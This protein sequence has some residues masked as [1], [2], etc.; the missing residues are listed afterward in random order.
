MTVHLVQEQERLRHS[1][2]DSAHLATA[3]SSGFKK[4]KGKQTA[5]PDFQKKHK[6]SNTEHKGSNTEH[7]EIK[8]FF[9]NKA[10]HLKK[11]CAKYKAWRVK[12][13]TSLSLVNTESLLVSVAK[14]TWWLDTGTTK[15]I[16][17]SL[18]GCRANRKPMESERFLYMGAGDPVQVEGIATFG[19]ILC[20]GYILELKETLYVSSFRRNLI[21]VSLLDKEGYDIRF[22]N[23][24]S[25]LR[26]NS[27]LVGTGALISPDNL[28]LLH[29]V[30]SN[31]ACYVSETRG[32]KRKL[33]TENSYRLWHRRL[34]HISAKRIDRLVSDEILE[35]LDHTDQQVC[36]ECIKG[37]TT[38]KRRFEAERSSETLKVVHTD[39]CGPF[40]TAS[41]NGQRYFISFIDDFS[42]Y[43]YI[44]LIKE[45][46]E[47][48]DAFKS[49]KTEV[50]NQLGKTIKA[51]RSDRGGEYYGRYDGLGE[52]RPGPFAQFLDECEIVPQYTMPRSPTMNG[53]SERRNRTLKDMVR[54]MI[55]NTTL[56][57]SL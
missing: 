29:T 10:G 51:V 40:P 49:F 52:Q 41:W 15:H 43:G 4:R 34:G 23:H 46:F 12:K 42:R 16:S 48:L 18:Q 1:Q 25:L 7:K 2:L 45:K 6:G 3:S 53:V 17:V 31:N 5:G 30:D 57:T 8:C 28:Y 11:D 26:F 36:I 22:G 14:N 20:T 44:H 38:N 37:K 39:I 27:T 19:L 56:P 55:A 54:S 21:S 24:K 33:P 35:T 47:A 32:I 9:C 50:E 13:G